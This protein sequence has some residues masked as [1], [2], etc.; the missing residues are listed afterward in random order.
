MM[1]LLAGLGEGTA[2]LRKPDLGLVVSLAP[3]W[4]CGGGVDVGHECGAVGLV[5]HM[6]GK[7]ANKRGEK[8]GGTR[9][10]R[11]IAAGKTR[12]DE[13][14]N[15]YTPPY[16]TTGLHVGGQSP[17]LYVADAVAGRGK[18]CLIATRRQ[19]ST[20]YPFASSPTNTNS[21]TNCCLHTTTRLYTHHHS[22]SQCSRP[23]PATRRRPWQGWGPRYATPAGLYLPLAFHRPPLPVL[24]PCQPIT[25]PMR[26]STPRTLTATG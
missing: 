7:Q 20:S 26:R 17:R 21:I 13:L 14:A 2:R 16:H 10:R 19:F 15:Y 1:V 24:A 11:C 3:V 18:G 22:P 23:G 5:G 12:G 8:R 9:Q 4:L 6:H 25:P